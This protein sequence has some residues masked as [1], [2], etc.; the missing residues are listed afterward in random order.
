MSEA[1]AGPTRDVLLVVPPGA[2][3][4][5]L[6]RL[7]KAALPGCR[8]VVSTGELQEVGQLARDCDVVVVDLSTEQDLGLRAVTSVRQ[9]VPH[10]AVVV[11]SDR[12]DLDLVLTVLSAGADEILTRAPL[13]AVAIRC[14]VRRREVA[15]QAHRE[16]HLAFSVFQSAETPACAI[17]GAGRIVVVNRAW[18]EFATEN[19]G[20][21]A[22]TGVGMSY[23]AVCGAAT[24]L[25][26]VDG[27][28]VARGLQDVLARRLPRFE[29]DYPCP[30]PTVERWFN[31]RITPLEGAAKA[32]ATHIDVTAAKRTEHALEHRSLHDPLTDLPNRT[33]LNDRLQQAFAAAARTGRPVGVAFLDLDHF[34]NVNDTLGHAAGD[35][36]L[37]A[38]AARLAQ[39]L[40]GGDTLARFAGDEFIVIWPGMDSELD[41]QQLG[42]RLMSCFDMPFA[43]TAASIAAS[44][45][46][47]VVV[48]SPPQPA[49]RLLAEADAA[50]YAAKSFGPGQLKTFWREAHSAL[51]VKEH[52]QEE[53]TQ[54]VSEHQ[55]AVYYQPVVELDD[56]KQIGAEALLRWKHPDGL[57]LPELVLPS[58]HTS[59]MIVPVGTW[60]LEQACQEAARWEADRAGL[61]IEVNL[62][63]Q[64]VLH[65]ELLATVKRALRCSGLE[66]HRLLVEV[67][68]SAVAE[69]PSA[70]AALACLA[71]L[72]V[73]IAIDDF[74]TD[75]S[76]LHLLEHCPID[77][78][79]VNK[80]FVAGLGVLAMD[81]A[82]VT[83]IVRLAHAVGSTC[84]AN[85]VETAEQYRALR[86]IG[87]DGAQ[88]F[89]IGQPSPVI[90][91]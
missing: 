79:K 71:S 20:D 24:G 53:I 25:D 27:K 39:Q 50:M 85:G 78:I 91:A 72:G 18:R 84:I 44:A 57:R 59:D 90:S 31:V 1:G 74:G 4:A 16:E 34:K 83:G 12:T 15:D 28:R 7:L 86:D 87:C 17:D 54:A 67:N 46:V 9:A 41:A 65:P 21:P 38:V 62:S 61:Q 13:I 32:A 81:D 48:G 70:M 77:V 47:G 82:I 49:E 42:Q 58:L 22:R 64:Q 3:A 89:F 88:G 66:A 33:L 56:G 73:R 69:D 52:L 51:G 2:S 43:L 36:L 35:E 75:H 11:W 37:T 14:A 23:L 40:R 5:G 29:Y 80:S 76:S 10:R 63:V 6:T 30:S 68:G 55:L 19:G 45:C 8:V 60:V 26:G